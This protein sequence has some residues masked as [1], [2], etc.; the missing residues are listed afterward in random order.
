MGVMLMPQDA[1]RSQRTACES[2]LSPSA[3]WILEIEVRPSDL[4][5]GTFD[6]YVCTPEGGIRSHGTTVVGCE[7]LC[8]PG[9]LDEWSCGIRKVY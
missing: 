5:T 8:E 1:H 4:V 9:P 3:M 7:S 6:V 2:P